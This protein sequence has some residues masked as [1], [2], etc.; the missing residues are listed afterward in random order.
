MYVDCHVHFWRLDRGEYQWIPTNNK[1]LAQDWLPAQL[2]PLLDQCVVEGVIVVQAASTVAETDYLLELA[3]IHHWILGVVGWM[4]MAGATFEYDYD[5]LTRNPK[6]A[7]IRLNGSVFQESDARRTKLILNRLLQLEAD[8]FPIDLLA[9]PH[10]LANVHRML[11]HVPGLKVA[12]NHLGIP[13]MLETSGKLLYEQWEAMMGLLSSFPQVMVKVSGTITQAGGFHPH[14]LKRCIDY[15]TTTFGP[16]RMMYGSD[17]PV[18]LQGGS[19][20]DVIRLFQ[21]VLPQNWNEDQ[22][23]AVRRMNTK[24]FYAV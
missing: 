4:D 15:L 21:K 8:E 22:L 2:K 16:Q 6:F 9:R 10:E 17:W 5:R 14:V 18:A 12:I 11:D 24:R 20:D 13:P 19:Y 1:I 7:G 23:N 3:Q